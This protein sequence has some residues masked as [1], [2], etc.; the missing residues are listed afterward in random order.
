V[1]HTL[2]LVLVAHDVLKYLKAHGRLK[3]R[4]QRLQRPVS[5]MQK[6]LMGGRCLPLHV[7][8]D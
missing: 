7:T 6:L 8:N 1:N 4:F 5:Q 3:W 2:P